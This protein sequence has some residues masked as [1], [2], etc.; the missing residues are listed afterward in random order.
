VD[1]LARQRDDCDC[2]G[3]KSDLHG[4]ANLPVSQRLSALAVV[5][6]AAVRV[7]WPGFGR[8]VERARALATSTHG[9]SAV[10]G[11]VLL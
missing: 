2:N 7:M 8:L 4:S 10:D 5:M 3:S 11:D 9:S 6:E 1:G